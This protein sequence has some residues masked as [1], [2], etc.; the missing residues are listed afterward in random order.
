MQRMRRE[1][2]RLSGFPEAGCQ[3]DDAD[4]RHKNHQQRGKQVI[5][6]KTALKQSNNT[7]GKSRNRACQRAQERVLRK[8][9]RAI[10]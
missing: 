7:G 1:Q 9:S 5:H 8:Q 6:M 2:Q 3:Q 10:R 4:G